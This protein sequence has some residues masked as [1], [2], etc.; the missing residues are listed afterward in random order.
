MLVHDKLWSCGA[1]SQFDVWLY[2]N[3]GYWSVVEVVVWRRLVCGGSWCVEE[4]GVWGEGCCVRT[5]VVG[6]RLYRGCGCCV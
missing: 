3:R 1:T 4:V 5:G 2:G 6:E